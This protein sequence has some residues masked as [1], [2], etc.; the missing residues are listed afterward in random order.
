MIKGTKRLLSFLLCGL[1][2][3]T[4]LPR[5][6]LPAFANDSPVAAAANTP[7]YAGT[8]GDDVYWQLDI[9]GT[10][11]ISGSGA[12][13]NYSKESSPWYQYRSQ[14][15]KGVIAN[16]V[17][18]ISDFAFYYCSA[19]NSITIPKSV[20]SIGEDAFYGCNGLKNVY[21]SDLRVW[22]R[23]KFYSAL[24][25]P[26]YYLENL[27]LNNT[28]IT[29]L[30]IPESVTSIGDYAFAGCRSFRSVKI[31]DSVTRIG[32]YAFYK[33]NN[34]SS[35]TLPDGLTSIQDAVFFGCTRLSSITIPK[36]VT[37][38]GNYAF[39][40]CSSL[41]SVTIPENVTGIGVHAFAYCSGLSSITLPES[42]VSLGKYAFAYCK[43]PIHV[44]FLG[45]VPSGSD[46]FYN[47]RSTAYYPCNDP[48]WT[49]TNKTIYGGTVTWIANHS[50][51]EN[52]L[53]TICGNSP[54]ISINMTSSYGGWRGAEI[55]IYEDGAL[56]TTATIPGGTFNQVMIPYDFRK[57]YTFQWVSG[58]YDS[59]CNFAI[60][61]GDE[62]LFS[63]LGGPGSGTFFTLESSCRHQ[64]ETVII[65]PTCTKKGSTIIM[66]SYCGCSLRMDNIPANGHHYLDGFCTVCGREGTFISGSCGNNLRWR[67]YDNGSLVI[68][69]TGPMLD[70]GTLED[71]I[72]PNTPWYEYRRQITQVEIESG[73]TTIGEYAFH[74]C[75]NLTDVA[76]SETI[77]SIGKLAFYQCGGLTQVTIPEGVTTI[78]SAA[79][80]RCS[81][82]TTVTLPGSLTTIGRIAFYDCTRLAGI[83]IPKGVTSIGEYTFSGC[84]G[85]QEI[86]FCGSAPTM[87]NNCFRSVAA[88]AI[89]LCADASWTDSL[90]QNYGGTILWTADHSFGAYIPNDDA[91]CTEDGTATRTCAFCQNTE[92]MTLPGT[93]TGH[94][95]QTLPGRPATC[96]QTGLT[97]GVKC[98]VCHE[99]L[100]TQETIPLAEHDYQIT[101]VS[102]TCTGYGYDLYQ[103]R[104]CGDIFY[105]RVIPPLGHNYENGRCTLC[106]KTDPT[107]WDISGDRQIN[108]V[109]VAILYAHVKGTTSITD[110]E[111]LKCADVTDDGAVNVADV[112]ALYAYV[113]DTVS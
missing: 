32:V 70:Y 30:V 2:L 36:S 72:T 37:G 39:H 41:T 90:R 86:I 48:V 19:M 66:C 85:L 106:G 97:E 93:A 73:V 3:V 60:V 35:I 87:E 78:G 103:C 101:K 40:S 91:T 29:D 89:Y 46:W 16:G 44:T 65:P 107:V 12:M 62:V 69:G 51:G 81:N 57:T 1:I 99:V 98:A 102:V 67:L 74:S 54:E 111:T 53:C 56:L 22:C 5:V 38:I 43:K 8:C 17:T 7:L 75:A 79:F 25:N 15:T 28:P 11:T 82:L 23:I 59:G 108:V 27:Y 104:S 14:I 24:S 95:V 84:T 112:S 88:T 68:S 18:G 83:T 71:G 80:R 13:W 10:L 6:Q 110:E 50:F 20:I 109:D 21:I 63:R 31:P 64:C 94:A 61:L 34:L 33:C 92:T 45:S 100:I 26:M 47:G 4:L 77:A 55:Q 52:G 49:S 42:L 58:S 9:S 96:M 105:N 113:T 76:I